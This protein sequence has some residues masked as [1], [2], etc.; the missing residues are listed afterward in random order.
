VKVNRHDDTRE[1]L[2]RKLWRVR[3]L[4]CVVPGSVGPYDD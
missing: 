4:R 3:A 1:W 2:V